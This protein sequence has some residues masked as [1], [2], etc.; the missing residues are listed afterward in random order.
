MILRARATVHYRSWRLAIFRWFQ[1]LEIRTETLTQ[2]VLMQVQISVHKDGNQQRLYSLWVSST[3]LQYRV[4]PYL[5]EE[6]MVGLFSRKRII[7][8]WHDCFPF[9]EE[10]EEEFQ[11]RLP[12][13]TWGKCG[14]IIWWSSAV[15][16]QAISSLFFAAL[17]MISMMAWGRGA[18]P[19]FLNRVREMIY[20]SGLQ[21]WT[22]MK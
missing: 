12:Y 1:Q 5:N 14:K 3:C 9:E 6:W 19:T 13:H 17:V 8:H 21:H 16:P 10:K 4:S 18:P 2:S 11:F 15:S 22:N 20:H 7:G